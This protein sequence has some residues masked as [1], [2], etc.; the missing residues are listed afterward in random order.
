MGVAAKII[1]SHKRIN[2]CTPIN[3]TNY[4]VRVFG[5]GEMA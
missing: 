4:C 2:V 5:H 1:P 3:G